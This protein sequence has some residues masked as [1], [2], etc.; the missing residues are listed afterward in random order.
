MDPVLEFASR[1]SWKRSWLSGFK[2]LKESGKVEG[3][4]KSFAL[5]TSW[6]LAG[7]SYTKMVLDALTLKTVIWLCWS[8]ELH[9]ATYNREKGWICNIHP[10]WNSKSQNTRIMPFFLLPILVGATYLL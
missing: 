5:T 4:C 10:V 6:L 8:K 2:V 7:K 3:D 1:F 9:A